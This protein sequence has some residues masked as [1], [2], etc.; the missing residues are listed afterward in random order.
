MCIKFHLGIGPFSL[1]STLP[2][3]LQIILKTR[4]GVTGEPAEGGRTFAPLGVSDHKMWVE[5]C[6]SVGYIACMAIKFQLLLGYSHM[7]CRQ[8]AIWLR[9]GHNLSPGLG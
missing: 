8:L 2:F 3:P 4:G 7:E 9:H 5:P 1:S 6:Y